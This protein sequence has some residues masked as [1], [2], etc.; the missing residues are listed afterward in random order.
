MAT[1]YWLGVTGSSGNV[2][3]PSNWTIWSPVGACGFLPQAAATGPAA[4]D[5]IVFTRFN[6]SGACYGVNY[7][8][9]VSPQGQMYGRTGA[10]ALQHFASVQV[11]SDC[12]VPMGSESVYFKFNATT[13]SLNTTDSSALP[14]STQSYIDVNRG[15]ASY[16]YPAVTIVAQKA[17]TYNI[18]GTMQ[19]ISTPNTPTSTNNATINLNGAT[20]N[21]TIFV[22]Q[23]SEA[24]PNN[25]T[26]NIISCGGT[27]DIR[28]HRSRNATF[29]IYP[30]NDVV[31]PNKIYLERS[32]LNFIQPGYSGSENNYPRTDINLE[33][34]SPTKDY[35][36]INVNQFVSFENLKLDGGTINFLQLP[37]EN[38]SSVTSGSMKVT[39]SRITTNSESVSLGSGGEF[40]L[41]GDGTQATAYT[42]DI[43]LSG[44][45]AITLL[46][47][48]V[49]AS[50]F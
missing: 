22:I 48:A 1:Y 20:I 19:R 10:G 4:N 2:N 6:V 25:T 45:W 8:P 44:N 40:L 37:S 30:G 34:I 32:T 26:Y 13:I 29:N 47:T 9:Q 35:P 15:S 11:L 31:S 17:H 5:T 39:T 18:K 43:Q 49:G 27:Y 42:P 50:G 16:A 24:S 46:P 21:D 28:E 14:N 36:N 3:N 12:P 41:F 33:T 23:V 38:P 7:Y